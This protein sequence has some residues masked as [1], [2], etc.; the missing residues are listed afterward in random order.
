MEKLVN[1]YTEID[2]VEIISTEKYWL[3]TTKGK[4]LDLQMGN[5]AFIFGY[6]DQEII[7][8]IHSNNTRFVRN[9][10]GETSLE[11][12]HVVSTLLELSKMSAISWTVSGT[13]AVETALAISADYWKKTDSKKNKVLSLIP[14]Y[15]GSSWFTRALRGEIN[16][17]LCKYAT[18]PKWVT[19]D[20]RHSSELDCLAE[21]KQQ[22][23]T[24]VIGSIIIESIPWIQGV[25]PFSSYFWTE[26]KS[27][28]NEYNVLI[29]LDDIAGCFG[30]VG[31]PF[32]NITLGIEVDI[33][34]VSKSISGGYAPIGAT[35]LNDKVYDCIGQDEFIH[36]YTYNPNIDGINAISAVLDKL[37][38]NVFDTE[39]VTQRT[40]QLLNELGIPFRNQGLC[41]DLIIDSGYE[42]F[43]NSGF[44]SFG[45]VNPNSIPLI[46]PIIADD[47]YFDFLKTGLSKIY[48]I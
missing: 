8:K 12:K 43:K 3:H 44:F 14:C 4:L 37:N 19:L 34:A 22:F 9:G 28:C 33:L 32:S 47:E 41:F 24:Q 45:I 31:K 35:L 25:Y 6:T 46:V 23:E 7:D 38:Q 18:A 1:K 30:K 36:T 16:S 15:H 40:I 5:S 17:D 21:I 39:Q 11:I 29:I 20:E 26:L 42:K 2:K 27:L 48:E 10:D 13:D